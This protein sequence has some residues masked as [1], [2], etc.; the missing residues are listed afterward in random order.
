MNKIT[1]RWQPVIDKCQEIPADYND[2]FAQLLENQYNETKTGDQ[3]NICDFTRFAL[4]T[5]RKVLTYLVEHGIKVEAV[6]EGDS[7]FQRL[8]MTKAQLSE[9]ETYW[10]SR[11][12]N[13]ID[14]ECQ[15]SDDFAKKMAEDIMALG[16]NPI[17][18]KVLLKTF[19]F[20]ETGKDQFE[21]LEGVG[22]FVME[23]VL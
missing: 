2:T 5:L 16:I 6:T 8:G 4:P 13:G 10:R 3:Y 19:P 20:A 11:C 18:L 14:A 21:G 23:H 12:I 9:L 22:G 17:K 7:K 15:L 1:E